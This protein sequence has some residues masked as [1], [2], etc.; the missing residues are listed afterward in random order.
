[1]K[2]W[3]MIFVLV[4]IVIFIYGVILI[5]LSLDQRHKMKNEI[6]KIREPAKIAVMAY[7]F[8]QAASPVV[9][10]SNPV[11]Y[12]SN[13]CVVCC[14]VVST[15]NSGVKNKISFDI[16]EQRENQVWKATIIAVSKQR[17]H[18]DA[19]TKI[20]PWDYLANRARQSAAKKSGQGR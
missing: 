19:N 18:P 16:L 1:M 15:D 20:T 8:N 6:Q 9:F 14:Y 13:G 11:F 17:Y 2:K 4:F 5:P 3:V 7:L 12:D 10:N